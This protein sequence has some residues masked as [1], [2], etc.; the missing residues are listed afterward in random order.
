MSFSND[1]RLRYYSYRDDFGPLN[2]SSTTHFIQLLDDMIAECASQSIHQLVYAV[3]SGRRPL[4][5]AV[6]LLGCYMI[7]KMDM[8]PD[9]VAARFAW[10][11]DERLEDFRDATS[12]PADFGLTLLDCWG[13]LHRGTQL[14]WVARPSHPGSPFWGGIDMEQYDHYDDPLEADLVEVVPLKLVAFR[15]PKDLG[16]AKYRDDE[17]R[18]TRRFGPEHFAEVLRDLDVSDVVRLNAPEYDAGV[19]AAAGIRHHELFFEDCTEPPPDVIAA[20]LRIVDAAAGVVAVHCLAGLGR[21]GTLIALYMM[22]SHGFTAREAMGWL[23]IMRPGSV[24]G[25]QQ[26][27]LCAVERTV[28]AAPG[29]GGGGGWDWVAGSGMLASSGGRRPGLGG[30]GVCRSNSGPAVGGAGDADA[31]GS[32]AA[33]SREEAAQV[34][35]AM[36]PQSAARARAGRAGRGQG[37]TL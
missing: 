37:R 27:F 28:R 23:R 31:G 1:R 36:G 22:R 25:E 29:G 5:N 19:F 9:Q 7:L 16:G 12:L 13:G 4:T 14:R 20:F 21:T 2:M 10:I 3:D 34:A 32:A 6:M 18:M 11:G 33:R 15:G 8:T 17:A 30:P 26:R 35:G 24:I